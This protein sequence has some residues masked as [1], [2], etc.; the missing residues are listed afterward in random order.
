[1]SKIDRK[2][3]ARGTYLVPEHVYGPIK[4]SG[5]G[6]AAQINSANISAE[7]LQTPNAPFRINLHMPYLAS[8]VNSNANDALF[9]V[10]FTLP[11]LQDFFQVDT[12]AGPSG[13]IKSPFIRESTPRLILEELS[14][15]FDQRAENCAIADQ[16]FGQ[17][18]AAPP[19]R[20]GESAEQGEMSFDAASDLSFRISVREKTLAMFTAAGFPNAHDPE[21]VVMEKE[22]FGTDI[23]S[24]SYTGS[25]LR[26]NPLV[27]TGINKSIN[28]YATH[29]LLLDL[30]SLVDTTLANG[31]L[32]LPSVN[33]SMKFLHPLVARDSGS[34]IQNL[35]DSTTPN[36]Q[37][38]TRSRA[39]L[40][41]DI[42]ISE[43]SS[44]QII[45]ADDSAGVSNEIASI[46]KVFKDGIKGG[47]DREGMPPDI[48]ELAATAGY[49]VIA[50]PLF[51]NRVNGGMIKEDIAAEP[52]R[53]APAA[54]TL[55]VWDSRVIPISHPITIHHVMLAWNW[56]VFSPSDSLP[57]PTLQQVPDTTTFQVETGVAIGTMLRSDAYSYNQV[58][59]GS[60]VSPT[61][62][63]SNTPVPSSTWYPA[64]VDRAKYRNISARR[65]NPV[66][67]A[68]DQQR[69]NAWDWEIHQVPILGGAAP[70]GTGY[71]PQGTPYYV[72][73]N[74]SLNESRNNVYNMAGAHGAPL[75][76][77]CEQFIEV[78]MKVSDSAGLNNLSSN[79]LVSGYGGHFVY[80]ICKKHLT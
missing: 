57:G 3:L 70:T 10:P 76:E 71:Y 41:K 63:L 13:D 80:I 42:T 33:V 54:D 73:R 56:T 65:K 48:E 77:G 53:Y 45:K 62:R 28:P 79:S 23:S 19:N 37:G 16:F 78:R 68:M 40:S 47:Y 58:A 8:D 25:F 20:D 36:N 52:N 59:F 18:T 22:I 2:R 74:W 5:D 4:S 69:L 21:N 30:K 26:N 72:G 1:M 44:G 7:Q 34:T 12:V 24:N 67:G 51:N 38:V 75:D 32:C 15:S 27:V 39:S 35:P 17:S 11:P 60:M 50:V 61:D 9:G 55:A 6:A 31:T 29:M 49:E 66:S 43:P 14:F 46:D 64:T